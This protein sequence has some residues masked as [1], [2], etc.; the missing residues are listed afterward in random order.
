MS[1]PKWSARNLG[2]TALLSVSTLAF[3]GEAS[4]V[5][6]TGNCGTLGADG[7][8]TASPEG[9]DYRWV[10]TSGGISGNTL[11]LGSDTNGSTYQTSVFSA[12][13]GDNLQFFF[14]YVTT[15]GA[16]YADYGWARLLDDSLNPVDVLFTARTTTGGNTVPGF[17]MPPI[18]ATIT[19]AFVAIVPGSPSWTPVGS[20]C[21]STGCGYTGWVQSDYTIVNSGNYILEFGSANWLDTA[22]DSGLAF[23]GLLAGGHQIDPNPTPEPAS[24]VLL[25]IGLAALAAARR[26]KQTA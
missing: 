14:N 13:A 8:V 5:V 3:T 22:Y 10:S 15:D 18:T 6:C 20:G 9:G 1:I 12:N 25:G 23:D 17:G 26:R 4:A 7:V 16:Q 11:H 2:L 24:L 21:Y 19:P